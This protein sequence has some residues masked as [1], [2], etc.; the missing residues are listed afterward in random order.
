MWVGSS[1]SNATGGSQI[2][3]S[4]CEPS[5][6]GR[7]V[8]TGIYECSQIRQLNSPQHLENLNLRCHPMSQIEVMHYFEEVWLPSFIVPQALWVTEKNKPK[9]MVWDLLNQTVSIPASDSLPCLWVTRKKKRKK[10]VVDLTMYSLQWDKVMESTCLGQVKNW[11]HHS[12]NPV[13]EEEIQETGISTFCFVCEY[14][15]IMI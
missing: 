1:D 14:L 12:V 9:Q 5:I 2:L 10:V 15:Y 4:K 7:S 8:Q 3:T 11:T 6:R 13:K